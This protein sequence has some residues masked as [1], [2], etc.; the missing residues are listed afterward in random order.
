MKILVTGANGY[1]GRNVVK[2]LCD[3]GFDVIATDLSNDRIDKRAKFVLAN[4]FENEDDWFSFFGHPDVCLHLAWRDGFNH[5]SEKHMGDLSAHF[6]FLTNLIIHGLPTVACMGTM[7]EIGYW[8]GAVDENTPCNPISQYGIA[9]NA[10]RRALEQ[11]C[12]SKECAFIWLRAFYIYGDDCYGSSVFC[13]IRQFANEGKTVFPF[14]TGN[15]QCDFIHIKDFSYQIA[16]AITQNRVTGIINCCSGTPVELKE[17][18]ENYIKENNLKVK[19]D[20]GKYPQRPYDSPCI[21]GDTSK[22]NLIL[23]NK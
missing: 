19:L 9:K 22:I 20:F 3:L 6:A 23:N 13:K 4:I 5:N 12:E 8:V 1:I 14:T 18:V 21:F 2:E 16:K 7:H 11:F 15:N 17:K 10:L